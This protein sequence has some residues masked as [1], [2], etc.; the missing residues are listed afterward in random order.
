VN[1]K[2]ELRV[3]EIF[4]EEY[5]AHMLG[6]IPLLLSHQVAG[7]KGEYA[8][9]TS[10]IIDAFL[11]QTMYFGLGTLE[12]NLRSLGYKRPMLI[13]HNSGGMAQLNSTDALQTVHS[14]PVSGIAASEHLANEAELGNVVATDMGGTSFD[15]GIVVQGGLKYYDFNPVI[16]RSIRTHPSND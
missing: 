13:C 16:D 3:R 2:H 10:T 9:A 14:G 6:A 11:H 7:R 4:L 1:P 12:L 8:R 15:I 5:P